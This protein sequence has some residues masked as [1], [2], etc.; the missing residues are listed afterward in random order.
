MYSRRPCIV[1]SG[2]SKEENKGLNKLIEYVHK[3]SETEVSKD[4]ITKTFHTG[5]EKTDKKNTHNTIIKF[6][7]HSFQERI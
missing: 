5:L 6:K 2:L 1:L 3:L 7:T 4:K